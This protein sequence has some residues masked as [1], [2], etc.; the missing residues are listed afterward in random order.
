ME[1]SGFLLLA[2]QAGGVHNSQERKEGK[3]TESDWPALPPPDGIT[4]I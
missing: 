4:G 1:K 2:A 3:T